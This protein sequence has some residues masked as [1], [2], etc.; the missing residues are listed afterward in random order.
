MM[1]VTES[2]PPLL[3]DDSFR[4][5]A[6][7]ANRGRREIPALASAALPFLTSS[8]DLRILGSDTIELRASTRLNYLKIKYKQ[9]FCKIAEGLS[10]CG[11][12]RP[13]AD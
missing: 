2:T 10:R 6:L 9:Q 11:R 5:L 1:T 12:A 3:R 4:D 7:T 8:S 13:P